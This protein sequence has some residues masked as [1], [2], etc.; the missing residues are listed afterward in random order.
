M[1]YQKTYESII[2][3]AKALNRIKVFKDNP[4]YV[5]Y[6]RHHIIP[7]C[8]NGTNK[9]EN[10]VLLTAK[11]HF[12]C[13]KLLTHIYQNNRGIALGYYRMTF[14]K[15]YDNII[16]GKDYQHAKELFNSIPIS[17]E[18]RLKSSISHKDQIPWNKGQTYIEIFG[19]EKGIK[20]KEKM[21]KPKSLET[22]LKMKKPKSQEH[23]RKLSESHK[24][25]IPWNKKF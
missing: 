21:C 8:L 18:T 14:S 11:E 10:L 6:E 19:E 22:K 3:N 20:L 17:K 7:K 16:S 12:V 5:Y 9:K 23:K 13:H 1:N 4:N 24:G 25:K 2:Q 15:R